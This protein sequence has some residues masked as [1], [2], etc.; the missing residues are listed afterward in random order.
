[1]SLWPDSIHYLK[2]HA[3]PA[4]HHSLIK[5]QN[6]AIGWSHLFCA[7]WSHHWQQ[8][9]H[10]YTLCVNLS[11]KQADRSAWV[12][13]ICCH[14]VQ[15][16]FD[17]WKLRNV[18]RHKHN[19]D[20]QKA[21][22][23]KFIHSQMEELYQSCKQTMTTNQHMYFDILEQHFLIHL[24]PNTLEDWISVRKSAI[25]IASIKQQKDSINSLLHAK[26]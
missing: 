9:P 5:S 14:L 4:P 3:Y 19:A 26:N 10:D 17:L 8:V 6:T 13:C 18:E 15:H 1:M 23:L 2:L 25:M 22:R 7:W 11:P 24:N 21:K 12:S 20:K 16:W